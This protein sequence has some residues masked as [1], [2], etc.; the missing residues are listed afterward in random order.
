MG[1]LSE[2]STGD[3]AGVIRL[4]LDMISLMDESATTIVAPHFFAASFMHKYNGKY[5]F[6]YSTT[7]EFHSMTI[8][9]MVSD[10]PVAGWEYVGTVLPNS[11]DNNSNNNHHSIVEF[12]GAWYIFY[13][14][15]KLSNQE[16][17]FD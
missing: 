8:D 1:N 3:N 7:F 5:F 12:E 11:A 14:N 2:T 17:L 6:F 10:N 4:N 9:C 15:R 13:H 16:G